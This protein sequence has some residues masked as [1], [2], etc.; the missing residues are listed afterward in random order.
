M[1]S[2]AVSK[3]E[4]GAY[5]GRIDVGR[6]V[7]TMACEVFAQRVG[8]RADVTEVNRLA[9]RLEQKQAIKAFEE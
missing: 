3:N 9:T 8:I 4:L 1:L 5:L 2:E 7:G 6:A